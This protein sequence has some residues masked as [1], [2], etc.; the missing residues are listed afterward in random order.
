MRRE[1]VY[2][3]AGDMTGEGVVSTTAWAFGNMCRAID[4]R[5]EGLVL[6]VKSCREIIWGYDACFFWC[7]SNHGK[8][9]EASGCGVVKA[10]CEESAGVG[11]AKALGHADRKAIKADA[12]SGLA[13]GDEAWGAVSVNSAESGITSGVVLGLCSSALPYAFFCDRPRL[14][15]PVA[16]AA[17]SLVARPLPRYFSST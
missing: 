4:S 2:Y 1:R 5:G 16:A 14:R 7:R 17:I 10:G 11:E 3:T 9:K 13:K 12:G 15:A 8:D 6:R